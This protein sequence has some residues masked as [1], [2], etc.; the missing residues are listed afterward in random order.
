MARG[1][2]PMIHVPDVRA[3]VDWYQSLGFTVIDTN[4]DDG[5]L[6]WAM[7]S[8]GDGAV[9]FHAGG[10]HTS[11]DRRDVDLYVHT[12][13]VAEMYA[14]L[15]GKVVVHEDLHDT[16]YGMREFIVRDLNGFWVTF[17]QPVRGE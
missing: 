5:R 10:R 16:F 17:G 9:M 2:T 6:D 15:R 13:D 1:V 12:E 14:R 8:F 4:E 3:T 7:L 11:R